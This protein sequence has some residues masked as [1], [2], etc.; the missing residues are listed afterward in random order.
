MSDEKYL[1]YHKCLG[2]GGG[3]AGLLFRLRLT[4][5]E[6]RRRPT[7]GAPPWLLMALGPAGDRAVAAA[8]AGG[9][10]GRG[11]GPSPIELEEYRL[12]L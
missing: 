12:P 3:P 7:N 11:D 5:R 9:G 1:E 6:R 2:Y 4:P 10:G 8:A